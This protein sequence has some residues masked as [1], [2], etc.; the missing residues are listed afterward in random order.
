M[1]KILNILSVILLLCCSPFCFIACSN[2][3]A[4][5]DSEV[6]Q[7]AKNELDQRYN[8]GKAY[9]NLNLINSITIKNKYK[10]YI[11][12]S[13]SN[14][15][16]INSYN[17]SIK[18]TSTDRYCNLTAN[19]TYK[20][21]SDSLTFRYTLPATKYTKSQYNFSKSGKEVQVD[22]H[23]MTIENGI[24]KTEVYVY[25]NL[26]SQKKIGFIKS[27]K[28]TINHSLSYPIGIGVGKFTT[29]TLNYNVSAGIA[30]Q[31]VGTLSMPDTQ[32]F[33][34]EYDLARGYFYV[35]KYQISYT[36]ST[37]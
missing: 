5:T 17:G 34:S 8:I 22:I 7:E 25:N 20:D 12:W 4:L 31:Y 32:N 35:S 37:F 13:S 2:N 1:K 28:I 29:L 16:F 9:D 36:E 24:L 11:T 19:F 14:E 18:R 27:L 6:I 23:T 3:R 10:V 33:N 21:L 15:S 26:R 30:Y